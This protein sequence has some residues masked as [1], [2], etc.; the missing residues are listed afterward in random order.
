MDLAAAFNIV[1]GAV[2]IVFGLAL[3]RVRSHVRVADRWLLLGGLLC[4]TR[5]FD[6][7]VVTAAGVD[8]APVLLVLEVV[9]LLVLVSLVVGAT[10]I[11]RALERRIDEAEHAQ[12]EY[13]RALLD[14]TQLVRHRIA[15]PLTA[16]KGGIQ[17]L[18][19]IDL[20]EPVRRNLLESM[21]VSATELERVAL[22]P[23][24]VSAEE[25]DL[26]PTP[27]PLDSPEALDT[28]RSGGGEVEA[29]F[30]DATRERSEAVGDAPEQVTFVC[31]CA[32]RDCAAPITMTLERYYEVHRDGAQ[33]VV[34]PDHDLPSIEDV[35]HREHDWWV[36]KKRGR[37][38]RGARR[39]A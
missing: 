22:H 17:T 15:N 5:A 31:E 33:F 9:V 28:L 38:A 35:V 27:A 8:A 6:R 26:R 29:D 10:K 14:Y 11:G 34:A 18:L 37:P 24:R 30:R 21:L 23:K 2:W 1:I 39:R 3:V 13:G 25:R 7:L 36:V 32:A 12:N 20:A 16:V 4:A 19:A